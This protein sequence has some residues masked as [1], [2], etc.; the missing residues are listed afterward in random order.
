MD[1]IHSA[2][3]AGFRSRWLDFLSAIAHPTLSNRRARGVLAALS[4]A[5]FLGLMP[6]FGKQAINQ[7]VDPIAV[8]SIRTVLA[9][10]LVFF[11]MLIFYRPYLYIYPAGL[12]GCFL[13][14]WVNGVGSLFYYS[15]LARIDA[16][17][18][19]MLYSLYPLF[20]I[21][22]MLIDRQIPSRITLFR[23]IL[24]LPAVLLLVQ[25]GSDNVDIS[26]VIMMLIA[27]ALFALHIPINQRVL[28]DMP[29]PTVTLYTLLAMGSVVLPAFLLSPSKTNPINGHAWQPLI[30]LTL[31]TFASRLTLFAGVKQ[32]G[33][34]Q[35]ALL[36]LSE[37]I[38]TVMFSYLWLGEQLTSQQWI[39][40]VLLITSLLLVYIDKPLQWTTH[41][42]QWFGWVKPPGMQ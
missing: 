38:I 39:G 29:S 27:A 3:D 6:I 1:K 19:H 12:L 30:I 15:A 36:G 28:A 17:V 7:G 14:G 32:I 31:I 25:I 42:S 40:A 37:L 16:S 2:P 5:V 33:G 18:G 35:T 21:L 10:I 9:A 11:A 34:L 26:G 8:V 13:A 20:L 23:L 4:S 22:W 41:K 24:A